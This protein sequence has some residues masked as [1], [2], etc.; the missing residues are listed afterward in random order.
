V[1]IRAYF[2]QYLR[3]RLAQQEGMLAG[4][5]P[6]EPPDFGPV[7][8]GLEIVPASDVGARSAQVKRMSL[9]EA[10]SMMAETISGYFALETTDHLLLVKALP[11]TGKTTAAVRVAEELASQGKRVLYAGPRHA[12]YADIM[13]ISQRP[14]LWYEWLPRQIADSDKGKVETCRYAIEIGEWLARGY[15]AM[16]F[17]SSVCGWERVQDG[18]PYHAQKRRR[19]PIIFGQHQHVSMGH[20]LQFHAVI[21]DEYPVASF[22]HEWTIPSKSILPGTLDRT[23]MLSGLL[24]QCEL[25][26]KSGTTTSGPALL[27]LLGGAQ[28]VLDA[29]EDSEIPAGALLAPPDLA[30]AEDALHAPYAHLP[31]TVPLL[32][33]EAREALKGNCDYPPRVLLEAEG[34]TL[35]TRRAVSD[36]LPAHVCWLD[37]TANEALYRRCFQRP[38]IVADAQPQMA[39]KVFQVHSRANGKST[40][41]GDG[42]GHARRLDQS[43]K[44]IEQ[45]IARH[46]YERPAVISFQG[47]IA[48]SQALQRLDNVHF[49]AARG[50]NELQDCDAVI[51]LGTPQPG[52]DVIE[53]MARMVFVERMRAFDCAWTIKPITYDYRDKDGQGRTYPVS[54]FWGDPDLQ[55]MLWSMREAEIIQAAHRVRP[56][57]HAVH[58][59]LLTNIPL[60]EL[61]P[62]ELLS[63]ADVMGAPKG[64]DCF[65]WPEVLRVAQE[66]SQE[67][68]A[69]TVVDLVKE[70]GIG[71]DTALRYLDILVKEHGWRPVKGA[72]P[73]SDGTKPK[74]GR[75]RSRLQ[76]PALT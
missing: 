24:H 29:C 67:R 55:E 37:A 63:M 4:Q 71:R 50:T 35:L 25:L 66:V 56:V 47:A 9:G 5:A 70:L 45:I 51:V 46:G 73:P 28:R 18:C 31:V 36:R 68:G 11:G 20:P 40:L 76:P 74:R 58:I 49:Y 64:V 13:G 8:R 16:D 61:P 10:R 42:A 53:R 32:V 17:C 6:E 44:Q 1:E 26:A 57:N 69:V 3:Q 14:E 12:F 7:L 39:G 27:D 75:P 62:D 34:L 52:P 23:V 48:S 54:G 72:E 41:V 21:G 22:C 30:R 38:A 33:A 43:E 59:W 19:E 15:R 65:T 2:E 60:A